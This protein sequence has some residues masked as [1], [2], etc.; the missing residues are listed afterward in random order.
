MITMVFG[1]FGG[2]CALMARGW[3]VGWGWVVG[4]ET[5]QVGRENWGGGAGLLERVGWCFP[6][7]CRE[8]GSLKK[9]NYTQ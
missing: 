7:L 2:V 8:W 9:F 6:Y 1:I 5:C 4:T 3:P